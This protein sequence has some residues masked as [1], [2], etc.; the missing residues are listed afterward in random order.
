[1]SDVAVIGATSRIG[2]ALVDRLIERGHSVVAVGRNAHRLARVNGSAVHHRADFDRPRSIGF[3]LGAAA[4]IVNCA[5]ARFTGSLL[6]V[7]SPSAQR[8]VIVGST[9]K[10]SKY[11][12][13]VVDELVAAED[14]LRAQDR[15]WTLIA[16][17]MIYG[18][19]VE[20]NV[21]RLI[22]ILRRRRTLP[23]PR[24]GRNLIQPIYF[25]DLAE[26][27]VAAVERDAGFGEVVVAGPEALTFA[28][29]ARTAARLMG[30]K[31][32]IIP[33]PLV[34]MRAGLELATTLRIRLP[35]GRNELRRFGE[36]RAFDITAMRESL[37][38]EP[39]PFEQGLRETLDEL[40]QH[41]ISWNRFQRSKLIG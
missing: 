21:A 4:V 6:R 27:L 33:L 35:I 10:L 2:G 5:H 32:A 17:T 14:L 23:L 7:L 29:M 22:D 40:E 37:G 26:A 31:V 1:M 39:R 30:T 12:D 25:R 36:H 9:R 19:G 8:L 38:V 18:A 3:A 20:N 34:L 28:T 11:P 41:P 24:G 13:T 16:P 15:P